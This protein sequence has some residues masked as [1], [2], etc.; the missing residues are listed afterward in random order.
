[1]L[2]EEMRATVLVLTILGVQQLGILLGQHQVRRLPVQARDGG[3][4]LQPHLT[5]QEQ[6]NFTR[7]DSKQQVEPGTPGETYGRS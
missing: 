6:N 2:W 5:H 7:P 4:T 3:Q 1:M